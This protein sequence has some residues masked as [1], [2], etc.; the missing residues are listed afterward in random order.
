[1]ADECGA[2]TA[3]SVGCLP[4]MLNTLGLF[5][6]VPQSQEWWNMPAKVGQKFTVI[7][8]PKPD[9][10]TGDFVSKVGGGKRETMDE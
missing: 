7:V 8:S 9:W 3:S 4:S 6:S 10:V 1:M 5:T 2:N